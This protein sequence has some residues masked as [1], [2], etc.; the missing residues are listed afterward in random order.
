M[1]VEMY[2]LEVH[3]D[4]REYQEVLALRKGRPWRTVFLEG[5]KIPETPRKLGRPKL[6]E[7]KELKGEVT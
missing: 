6:G 1:R 5:L 4:S 3:L 2:R 7:E